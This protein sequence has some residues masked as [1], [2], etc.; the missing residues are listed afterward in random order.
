M[1]ALRNCR[2]FTLIE[3]MI[4]VAV[5]GILAA[6]AYPSYTSYI[7]RGKRAECRSGLLRAAQQQER[8]FTQFNRY[9]VFADGATNAAV[10]SF[11][12]DSLAQSACTFAAS[13]CA[14][15]SETACI[16]LAATPRYGDRRISR[17]FLTSLGEKQCELK[18]GNNRVFDRTTCW[19]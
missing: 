12:G 7:E 9:A 10:G 1:M 4:V 11:S 16:D 8:F 13:A 18:G 15:S 6:L 3:L 5:I 14:G 19:P 2:G 17:L